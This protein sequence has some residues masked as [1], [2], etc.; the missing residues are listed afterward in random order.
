MLNKAILIGHVGQDPEIKSISGKKMASFSLATSERWK[1]KDSGERKEATTWHRI[2]TF[3][4]GLVDVIEKYVKKGSKLYVE[5]TITVRKW[6]DDGIEKTMNEI[7]V[8]MSGKVIM[9]DGNKGEK[10]PPDGAYEN[11]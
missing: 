1:D 10:N 5:G 2:V 4:A 8:K 11:E 6:D 3:Q 9:L 7:T